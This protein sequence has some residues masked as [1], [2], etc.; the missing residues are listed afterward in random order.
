MSER[1][2]PPVPPEAR[3]ITPKE[4]P[5]F[6]SVS[7]DIK[8]VPTFK[9]RVSALRIYA[10]M[11]PSMQE[12]LMSL[13]DKTAKGQK[14][15]W[16]STSD[17]LSEISSGLKRKI[18]R[19]E[20]W[21]KGIESF[22][23]LSVAAHKNLDTSEQPRLD[24]LV[25]DLIWN[26]R[27]VDRIKAAQTFISWKEKTRIDQVE[28]EEAQ[29]PPSLIPDMLDLLDPGDFNKVGRKLAELQDGEQTM[30]NLLKEEE[31]IKSGISDKV[32]E[33][34]AECFI[35]AGYI[36][37][38]R[39]D[40]LKL[41]RIGR[42]MPAL[43]Y[44][45]IKGVHLSNVFLR[46]EETSE[47][48]NTIEDGLKIIETKREAARV[49]TVDVPLDKPSGK[50]LY[51]SEILVGNSASDLNFF[52]KTIDKIGTLSEDMK[53][54]V[55]V[56]SGL[57]EGNY[58]SKE[59]DKGINIDLTLD[60]QF[61]MAKLYLDKLGELGSKV[62]YTMGDNDSNFCHE[63]TLEALIMMR[64]MNKPLADKDKPF[65]SYYRSDQLKQDKAYKP[66]FAFQVDVVLEYCLSSGRR[67]RSADEVAELTNGE[68]RMEEY[69]MLYDSYQALSKGESI[70][71]EYEK[72]LNVEN[73][74]FP[75]KQF[76]KFQ[77]A[78]DFDLRLQ[79]TGEDVN[80]RDITAMVK[81]NFKLTTNSTH[82]DP[83][84]SARALMKQLHS[85][86]PEETIPQSIVLQHPQQAFT[87]GGAEGTWVISTPGFT[88][89]TESLKQRGSV[90]AKGNPT[91]WRH[92]TTQRLLHYPASTM[93][94]FTDDGRHKITIFNE[95]LMEKADRG[96]RTTLAFL[97]DWQTGSTTQR[98]DL[99]VK[100]V[101]L[102]FSTVVP[103]RPTHLFLAG[104]HIQGRNYPGMPN[105]NSHMMLIEME[106]QQR[107]VRDLIEPNLK[108][109]SREDF[110]NL[111]RVG[112]LPGNH[113][114]NSGFAWTGAIFTMFLEDLFT[115][116]RAEKGKDEKSMPVTVYEAVS[117]D[118]GDHFK[119]WTAL[120]PDIAGYGVMVQHLLLEKGGKGATGSPV[121]QAKS[122]KE[123][124]GD[125][126]KNFDFW[127]FGHW[128]HPQ[129]GIYGNKVA[130]I[131]PSLAG[132]SGY[133]WMRGHRAVNGGMMMH[134]GG[135]LPPQIEFLSADTLH[136][137]K[138][139]DENFYSDKNL[140]EL[141]R[142]GPADRDFDPGRHG[143]VP[144]G[145]DQPR[146]PLQRYLWENLREKHG[147]ST[148]SHITR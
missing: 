90:I 13:V 22:I 5:F 39:T 142:M 65:I 56:V 61:A 84:D 110:E 17:M 125:L 114:W 3:G 29:K 71:E 148:Q 24:A 23:D 131:S 117:T 102:L 38:T 109:V 21:E 36:A 31:G 69:L 141:V 20:I 66:H 145:P 55:I 107:Y 12:P 4:S 57:V 43:D 94:E 54:D 37:R 106:K 136:K 75:G 63:G 10:N 52:G 128:H 62:V 80:K 78:D 124:L 119:S 96:P 146:S 134:I 41:T 46:F 139:S 49:K 40:K 53:P 135:D 34:I 95:K 120:E 14:L 70:P 83:T 138:I 113:E 132:M 58:K 91:P 19:E 86:E 47:K 108:H 99:Q 8:Q 147:L 81:H 32:Q 127:A 103:E 6:K 143:F 51:L 77:F 130:A 25:K 15:D 45:A 2:N 140:K 126:V 76:D 50:V 98:S 122:I 1:L 97:M 16:Q 121:N 79:T 112:I 100:M 67:L 9:D 87:V 89:T 74:P 42:E 111:K 88:K 85:E 35:D 59:K 64:K 82:Q 105:E 27:K 129:Y 33:K 118:Y 30:E 7:P 104:D 28:T 72:V 11:S 73:I 26:E 93:H 137:H 123:G 68:M 144:R 116:A 60:Q 101:D 115:R 133:E 18:K 92:M 44:H 48:I